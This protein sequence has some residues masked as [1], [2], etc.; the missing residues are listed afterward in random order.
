M[1]ST[2]TG[3]LIG[4]EDYWAREY[5]TDAIGLVVDYAFRKLNLHRPTAGVYAINQASVRAFLK[6]GFT[7]EGRRKSHT[8]CD[9]Q[10]VDTVL[11]G[12]VRIE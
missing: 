6:A 1:R 3:I 11:V 4:E 2:S 9:G 7:E 5:A 10:Y 8:Y 12:T